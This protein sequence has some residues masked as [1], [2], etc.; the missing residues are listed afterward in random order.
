M[1]IINSK[2]NLPGVKPGHF[3]KTNDCETV[4]FPVPERLVVPMVMHMGAPCEPLVKKGDPVLVGQK[5]GESQAAF[6]APIHASCSGVVEEI[7]DYYTTMGSCCKAVVIK[8]DGEQTM[9]PAIRKPEI[10]SKAD[11]IAAIKESGLVGLGGAGFPTFMKLD[12]KDIDRVHTLVINAAE[13]EPYITA[14]YRE[15]L[16]NTENIVAGVRLVKRYLGIDKVYIGVESNKPRAIELLDKAFD[17]ADN[18]TVV[19]LKSLY[20]QGAE[21]SIIYAT[22]GIVVEKGKLP[23]DCGAIVLNVS[24]TGFI[25]KYMQDGIPLISKRITVDGD[26]VTQPKNLRVPI[27]TPIADVLQYCGIPEE[28]CG[29]ILMG[30]PMMGTPVFSTEAA[31]IKNNNAVTVL[32]HRASMEPPTTACIRCSKCIGVCPV[33]LMP[34]KLERAYDKRDTKVLAELSVDLCINCGCCSFICP[35][36][37]HLAQKNQLAKQLMREKAKGGKK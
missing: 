37:R 25:G 34:A 20:P 35:A 22:S 32:S 29:K 11:F 23:A 36:H 33:S 16:E 27:G 15:C 14:D 3:K 24:T 5:I 21:K 28:D 6:S 7:S 31:I 18:V 26:F 10:G 1:A 4:D 12:Y 30:G 19:R 9:D 17:P 8:T 13:C 2:R